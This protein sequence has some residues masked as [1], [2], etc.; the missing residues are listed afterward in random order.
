MKYADRKLFTVCMAALALAASGLAPTAQA[1]VGGGGG[2]GGGHA[3]GARG[4]GGGGGAM[5]G[6]GG[7]GGGARQVNNQRTDARANN[8]RSTSVNNVNNVNSNRNVNVN[9]NRNV[10]VNVDNHGGCCGWDNDYHPVA[11]AAAVTATVAVTSAVIGSMVRTV[12]AGCVPVNYGGM[13]YQQCGTTWY[14]PQG[15][16][17]IVVNA[18]Y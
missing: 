8:V 3:A 11:T 13:V 1:R 10:N 17:Y 7:G 5:A 4:G 16:Q 15:S 18:P 2:G 14:Q 9:S 12:P 6:G